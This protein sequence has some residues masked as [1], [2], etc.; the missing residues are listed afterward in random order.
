LSN[1]FNGS[2][3]GNFGWLSWSSDTGEPSLVKSLTQPGDSSTYVNP[4]NAADHQLVTGDWVSGRPG[5][6]NSKAVRAQLDALKSVVIVVPVWDRAQGQGNNAAYHVSA[7]ANIQIVSYQLATQNRITARFLGFADCGK[8][9]NPPLFTL[10]NLNPG[11]FDQALTFY[12]PVGGQIVCAFEDIDIMSNHSD[13]DFQDLIFTVK[14]VDAIPQK[15]EC[16]GP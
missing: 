4:D 11:Q 3:S 5:V 16:F 8:H 9:S 12:D 6:S 14:P 10:A 15:T 7:F 2:Q 13:Q 1:I